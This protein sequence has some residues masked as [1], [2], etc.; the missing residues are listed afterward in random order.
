MPIAPSLIGGS[1]TGY[2]FLKE[3]QERQQAT[4]ETSPDIERDVES[5]REK[6]SQ[7]F[8]LDDLMGDRQL[9]RPVL[10]SFGLE[11]ELDKG[12]F[13]RRII[14]DGPDDPQG[15]ARR[16]NN[17]DFIALADAFKADSEGN[18]R[19]SHG[20]IE[21]MIENYQD[22]AF[23]IAVGEQ[24]QDLRLALNF[25]KEISDLAADS[26]T[27]RAFW[28]KVIGNTPLM[29]VFST[30]LIL[31]DGLSNLDI[32]KQADYL[33]DRASRLIGDDPRAILATKEGAEATVRRFITQ[34]QVEAG[35][36]ALTPGASAITLLNAA[37]GG[38][39]AQS[40]SSLVLSNAV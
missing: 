39:G 3:T 33:Q 11:G 24:E 30:A 6:L 9:L 2:L 29:E 27:D 5:L 8:T 16:L 36:G 25:E 20:Q 34:R 12:A 4:F 18:I 35:P 14:E 38:F 26:S 13:V 19:L 32:E 10:Q 7:P 40:L 15:F 23:Q 28:F 21:D 22:R 17:D 31:P 1:L 37:A